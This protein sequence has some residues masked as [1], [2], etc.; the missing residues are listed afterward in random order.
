MKDKIDVSE[1]ISLAIS[2]TQLATAMIT[3]ET[4]REN[5]KNSSKKTSSKKKK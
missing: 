5:K 2:L 1:I 3:L 4:V